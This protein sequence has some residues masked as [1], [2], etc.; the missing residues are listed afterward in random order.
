MIC[1]E[2][3]KRIYT[4]NNLLDHDKHSKS[5][6]SIIKDVDAEA[7]LV[8]KTEDNNFIVYTGEVVEA[9]QQKDE[10]KDDGKKNEKVKPKTK[11]G[12]KDGRQS[13]IKRP[14]RHRNRS[15]ER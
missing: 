2:N 15:S 8:Q 10:V 1:F 9:D 5:V 14:P 13:P 3:S 6:Y 12:G 4:V 7:F 11:T